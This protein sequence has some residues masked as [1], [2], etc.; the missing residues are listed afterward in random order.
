M[1]KLIFLEDIYDKR[2][3]TAIVLYFRFKCLNKYY[4]L[5]G[6]YSIVDSFY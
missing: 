2:V 1:T 5:T 4:I 6:T 3:V